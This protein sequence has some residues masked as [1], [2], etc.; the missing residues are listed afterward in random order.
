MLVQET[1]CFLVI[2]HCPSCTARRS[3][4][5]SLLV[6]IY[7]PTKMQAPFGLMTIPYCLIYKLH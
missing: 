6:N 5:P 4:L 1:F 3:I 7:S 2:Q